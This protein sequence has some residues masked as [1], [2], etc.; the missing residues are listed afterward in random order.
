MS[1]DSDRVVGF[2]FSPMIGR[3]GVGFGSSDSG[4]SVRV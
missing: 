4:E 3:D 1:S 2:G